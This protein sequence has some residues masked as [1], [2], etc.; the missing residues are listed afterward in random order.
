MDVYSILVLHPRAEQ[1]QETRR[2]PLRG[3][4]TTEREKDA[5]NRQ[6]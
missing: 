3:V 6:K 5:L 4:W 2:Q 1:R